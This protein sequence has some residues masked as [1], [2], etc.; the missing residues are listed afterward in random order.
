MFGPQI[1]F[2]FTLIYCPNKRTVKTRCCIINKVVPT[3]FGAYVPSSGAVPAVVVTFYII[4]CLVIPRG[5]RICIETCRDNLV[6]DTT[7]CFNYAFVETINK[8]DTKKARCQTLQ[9]YVAFICA[10]GSKIV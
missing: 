3:C 2:H 8:C 5:W 4:I 9:D 7:Y 1:M 6:D 10:K